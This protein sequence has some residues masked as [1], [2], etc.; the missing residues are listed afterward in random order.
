MSRIG[1]SSVIA[2]FE[3]PNG[4]PQ[5]S[6]SLQQKS[7][8]MKN[9]AKSAPHSRQTTTIKPKK[10]EDYDRKMTINKPPTS[11]IQFS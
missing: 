6:K 10:L 9:K 1:D 4:H 2:I 8:S 3:P 11:R 7:L 5:K